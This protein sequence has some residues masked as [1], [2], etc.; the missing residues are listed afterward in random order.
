MA[1]LSP[2]LLPPAARQGGLYRELDVLD[3]LQ[4]TLSDGYEIF[5]SVSLHSDHDGPDRQ[6]EIDIVVLGPAG[7]LLLI[8]VKAGTVTLRDGSIYKLYGSGEKDVARQCRMQF[9]AM[10][11]RLKEAGL[12]PHIASCLVLPDYQVPDAHIAAMP[13]SRIVDATQYAQLGSHVREILSA[14]TAT[15]DVDALRRFLRNEFHVVPDL[16]VMSTQLRQTMRQISG[17]L[18]MRSA[19]C[20]RRGSGWRISS[21]SPDMG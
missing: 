13:R 5:H 1:L 15:E 16:S 3:R 17:G 19:C 2:S 7:N 20:W 4:V 14:A 21:F 11:G 10:L 8:E 9:N 6:R 12:H 18:A